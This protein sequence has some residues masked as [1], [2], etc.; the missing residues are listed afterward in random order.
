MSTL[1]Q[2]SFSYVEHKLTFKPIYLVICDAFLYV[3]SQTLQKYQKVLYN[4]F[5]LILLG[6]LSWH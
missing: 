5:C 6:F 4:K 1:H 3:K 2:I